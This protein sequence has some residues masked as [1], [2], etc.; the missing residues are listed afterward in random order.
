[1]FL[2]EFSLFF[3]LFYSTLF[4]F[5][6]PLD[7]FSLSFKNSSCGFLFPC[8]CVCVCVCV[9]AIFLSCRFWHNLFSI[10]FVDYRAP[11]LSLSLWLLN[12]GSFALISDKS[13]LWTYSEFNHH[14][15]VPTAWILLTLSFAI[16]PHRLSLLV[17]PVDGIQ[18]LHS[19]G[20]CKSL[21]VGQK[22]VCPSV[23]VQM[24]TS[25]MSSS[26]SNGVQHILLVLIG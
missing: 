23:K 13:K 2:L 26:F 19:A 15:G 11:P 10:I 3:T 24:R 9:F 18:C 12:F 7:C 4:S 25:L 14:Q 8:V 17:S 6:A 5:V 1:M 16:R 20:E 22:L 21:L